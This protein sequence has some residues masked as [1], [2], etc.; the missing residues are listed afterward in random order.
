LGKWHGFMGWE[1]N[2]PA[3]SIYWMERE[4]FLKRMQG[5]RKLTVG[6]RLRIIKPD[7]EKAGLAG[8]KRGLE[9][10]GESYEG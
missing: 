3:F 8:S 1:R 2:L 5:Y 7:K 4:G 9:Q 10:E 6:R